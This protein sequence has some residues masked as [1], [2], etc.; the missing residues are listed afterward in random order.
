[1]LLTWDDIHMESYDMVKRWFLA[2]C[3]SEIKTVCSTLFISCPSP[4][5]RK[6]RD[7]KD[8][9]SPEKAKR[10]RQNENMTRNMNEHIWTTVPEWVMYNYTMCNAPFPDYYGNVEKDITL[11]G[12][13]W[14]R[15]SVAGR[16]NKSIGTWI[17]KFYEC[18]EFNYKG[19]TGRFFFNF[20]SLE[21]WNLFVFN[22]GSCW[23]DLKS[24]H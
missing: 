4:P 14:S 1:M 20:L 24:S 3:L 2:R 6:T 19:T 12:D 13:G 21:N 18:F 11:Q 8:V 7:K 9:K 17:E 16:R 5:L 23:V 22:M 10:W 15:A